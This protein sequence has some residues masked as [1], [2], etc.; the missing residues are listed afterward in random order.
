[1]A[2]N[3]YFPVFYFQVSI[4]NLH[5]SLIRKTRKAIESNNKWFRGVDGPNNISSEKSLFTFQLTSV[6]LKDG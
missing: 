6:H 2:H 4:E 5:N 3:P 1:M